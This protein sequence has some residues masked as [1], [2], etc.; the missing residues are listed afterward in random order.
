[1][2]KIDFIKLVDRWFGRLLVRLLPRPALPCSER[3]D[4]R[5]VL[6]I[7][8]GGIGDALLLSVSVAVLRARFPTAAIDILAE[9]RNAGAFALMPELREVFAYDRPAGLISV[10]KRRYDVTIDTEQWHR[11]SAV[12]C[13]LVRSD[14]KIGFASNE[15]ARLF[16]HPIGYAL[17]RYEVESFLDLLAPLEICDADPSPPNA[18][19]VPEVARQQAAELLRSVEQKPLLALFAGA[20]IPEKRWAVENFRKVIDWCLAEN[21]AVTMVGGVND[22]VINEEIAAG[23]PVLNLAGRT[24]LVGT[25]AILERAGCLVSGDSGVLHLAVGLGRPTV[26]LF[27]PSSTSKWAPRGEQHI[28]LLKAD[29]SPC[30]QYGYTPECPHGVRCMSEISVSDVTAAISRLM[31]LSDN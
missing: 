27:G 4:C 19:D 13:R 21:L 6:L 16:T 5:S 14:W 10:L 25:A 17:D 1:M 31:N 23:R 7:R 28:T 12:V 8:P 18:L 2:S 3:L 15:R 24:S 11:L 26:S 29:C 20:S 30:S 9:Q 22:A